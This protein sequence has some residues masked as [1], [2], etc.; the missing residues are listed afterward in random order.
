MFA[1]RNSYTFFAHVGTAYKHPPAV[2]SQLFPQSRTPSTLARKKIAFP[3]IM[4]LLRG[5]FG[6]GV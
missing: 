4:A 5:A 6:C 3:S 2:S 1:V